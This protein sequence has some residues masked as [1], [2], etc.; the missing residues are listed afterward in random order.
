MSDII[1]TTSLEWFKIDEY[2]PYEFGD[3]ILTDGYITVYGAWDDELEW[4]ID[5][6]AM[7]PTKIADD[8]V[9]VAW[10]FM[11][12]LEDL[13]ELREKLGILEDGE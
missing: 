8:F 10:A 4:V 1:C 9:P 13:R 11:P 2:D 12:E 7:Y 5:P 3:V 6:H